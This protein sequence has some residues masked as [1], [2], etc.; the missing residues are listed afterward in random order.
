MIQ[1]LLTELQDDWEFNSTELSAI[2]SA[3]LEYAQACEMDSSVSAEM[4]AECLRT[5]VD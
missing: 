5:F 3:I 2:K 1:E 4:N